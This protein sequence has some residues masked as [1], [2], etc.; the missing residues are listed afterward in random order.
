MNRLFAILLPILLSASLMAAEPADR[1]KDHQQLRQ[2]LDDASEAINQQDAVRLRSLLATEF[3]VT[4]VNQE[5]MIEAA[6][7]NDFFEK[8]FVG[9]SAP[10]KSITVTPEA[11]APSRFLDDDVAVAYGHSDDIYV[12]KNGEEV[13]IPA[14]WTATLVRQKDGWKIRAFHAGVNLL[15][16]PVLAAAQNHLWQMAAAGAVAGSL[17]MLLLVRLFRKKESELRKNDHET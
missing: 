8:H 7:L 16:N 5:R 6:Q 17:L 10:L 4:M 9:E 12:L 3:V 14:L 15:D 1:E 13:K 2:L 11:D